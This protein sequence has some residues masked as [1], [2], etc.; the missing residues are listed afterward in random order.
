ATTTIVTEQGLGA[1]AGAGTR[2]QVGPQGGLGA[3]SKKDHPLLPALPEDADHAGGE[4]H[5]R[6]VETDQLGA[7]D[8]SGIEQLEDGPGAY[9]RVA[10]PGDVE[11]RIHLPLVEMGGDAA[12]QARREQGP[13][14]VL[15]EDAL[16]AQE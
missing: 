8:A 15:V 11:E 1:R 3:P 7:A 14:R 2:R 10:A 9:R 12:L 16:P 6:Q 4:V 5:V 13:S